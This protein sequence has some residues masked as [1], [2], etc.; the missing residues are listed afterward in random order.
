MNIQKKVGIKATVKKPEYLD[1]KGI[2]LD[3]WYKYTG[4]QVERSLIKDLNHV[5][6]LRGGAVTLYNVSDNHLIHGGFDPQSALGIILRLP[7]Y[8]SGRNQICP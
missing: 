1:L 5:N 7:C 6:R 4:M 3:Y 8:K 2:R